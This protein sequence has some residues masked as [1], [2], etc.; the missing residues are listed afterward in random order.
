MLCKLAS[1]ILTSIYSIK[2]PGATDTNAEDP[3][4]DSRC[5]S[6][7]HSE[8]GSLPKQSDRSL[9]GER[10]LGNRQTQVHVPGMHEFQKCQ[11]PGSQRHLLCI[12]GKGKT[13][14]V[15]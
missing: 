2:L 15:K 14:K 3:L 7:P 4:H 5:L 11:V 9:S 8:G 1:Y 13:F 12:Q 10:V 6:A